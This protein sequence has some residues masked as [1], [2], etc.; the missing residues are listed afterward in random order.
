[1]PPSLFKGGF[2]IIL[3]NNFNLLGWWRRQ[4]GII[5]F[6][7]VS[8]IDHN[9]KRDE[10]CWTHGKRVPTLILVCLLVDGWRVTWHREF[11]VRQTTCKLEK[12][13]INQRTT[14]CKLELTADVKSLP[15]RAK[16]NDDGEGSGE[17]RVE[18]MTRFIVLGCKK[19]KNVRGCNFVRE[20]PVRRS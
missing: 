1:M 14:L 4:K 2:R 15:T 11:G 13:Q 8:W 20:A 6:L 7:N 16:P 5:S 3:L 18:F 17:V 10:C 19:T 12:G 9:K